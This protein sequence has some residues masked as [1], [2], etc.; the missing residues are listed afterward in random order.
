MAPGV[1]CV[2]RAVLTTPTFLP[3]VVAQS[4]MDVTEARGVMAV[5]QTFLRQIT[6]ERGLPETRLEANQRPV[7]GGTI[8]S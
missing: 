4:A 1:A 6:I 2:I 3:R 5:S 8:T 7:R